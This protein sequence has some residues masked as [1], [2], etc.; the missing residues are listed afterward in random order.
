M[1]AQ[2][3]PAVVAV[4]RHNRGTAWKSRL[5][6]RSRFPDDIGVCITLAA[7]LQHVY[8][9]PG[10]GAERHGRFLAIIVIISGLGANLA[11]MLSNLNTMLK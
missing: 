2:H 11:G 7:A 8:Q 4:R 5:E 10:P 9:R 1:R 6:I 3:E